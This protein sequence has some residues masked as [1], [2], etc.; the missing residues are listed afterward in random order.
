M[1][2]RTLAFLPILSL[3]LVSCAG[4]GGAIEDTTAGV[5]GF[6]SSTS[7]KIGGLFNRDDEAKTLKAAAIASGQSEADRAS[8]RT[9]QHLLADVGYA[10]GPADGIYG[11]KTRAAIIAYQRKLELTPDGLIT[12][13]LLASLQESGK[14]RVA[15]LEE[16]NAFI[17]LAMGL[18]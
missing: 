10:P 3:V 9:I 5:R 2:A 12:G 4:I 14:S 16:D 13:E 1:R 11:P 7:D 17:D 18:Q 15:R 8:V 6:V